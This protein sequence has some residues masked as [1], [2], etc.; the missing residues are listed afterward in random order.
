MWCWHRHHSDAV[1]HKYCVIIL[2]TARPYT[3][4]SM[5]EHQDKFRVFGFRIP[6]YFWYVLSGFLCDL[7]QFFIDGLLFAFISSVGWDW[8]KPTVCWTVSYTASIMIR[9]T[10][11]RYLVF[12]EFEGTYCASLGRTYLT[13]S[14]SIV[15]S[16]LSNHVISNTLGFSH[17][18]AWFITMLWT[19]V[20]NYFLLKASWNAKSKD[21]ETLDRDQGEE[22][23]HLIWL[24][25]SR[26]LTL[27][28]YSI[29]VQRLLSLT[30]NL[31][32]YLT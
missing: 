32:T 6:H 19:G 9:H 13:Y 30:T 21:R 12:G 7:C 27:A 31:S 18:Q 5:L 10:S 4:F 25:V 24:N 20:L 28:L 23:S 11:H 8:E 16:M 26:K 2:A 3:S 22:S 29:Y 15:L 17:Y 14:T 1:D